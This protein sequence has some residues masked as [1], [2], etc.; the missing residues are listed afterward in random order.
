MFQTT[1]QCSHHNLI[2]TCPN[3]R[4]R[5]FAGNFMGQLSSLY[6]LL[7]LADWGILEVCD[8]SSWEGPSS[9]EKSSWWSQQLASQSPKKISKRSIPM[10]RPKPLQ[11]NN[12]G[13]F[14]LYQ[15]LSVH[16]H[17]SAVSTLLV[18]QSPSM[19]F[20]SCG[21]VKVHKL[22]S[23]LITIPKKILYMYTHMLHVWNIEQHVP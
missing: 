7:K 9:V 13:S 19:E 3:S 10:L 16:Q 14:A 12:L 23:W 22:G 21:Y 18:S 8:L 2:M 6:C 15:W 5:L 4:I 11:T 1:N 20:Q 17:A